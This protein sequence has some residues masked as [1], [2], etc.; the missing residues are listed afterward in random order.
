MKAQWDLGG[1]SQRSPKFS[2]ASLPTHCAGW[3]SAGHLPPHPFPD[4]ATRACSIG[5]TSF[6]DPSASKEARR[7]SEK[8]FMVFKMLINRLCFK[9]GCVSTALYNTLSTI[10]CL[11]LI[12]TARM[13]AMIFQL[14]SFSNIASDLLINFTCQTHPVMHPLPIREYV[15]LFSPPQMSLLLRKTQR[16]CHM[17]SSS[18]SAK[19]EGTQQ[20]D[21]ENVSSAVTENITITAAVVCSW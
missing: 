21:R 3:A 12:I 9:I 5:S 2:V 10:K 18:H 15:V 11:G 4:M 13:T 7:L 8:V 16:L 19:Q 6:S 1:A 14:S 20:W 17:N